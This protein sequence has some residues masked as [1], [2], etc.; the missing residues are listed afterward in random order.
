M[1]YL[2]EFF[3]SHLFFLKKKQYNNI[4]ELYKKKIHELD[5][6]QPKNSNLDIYIYIYGRVC[7][8]ERRFPAF[9]V[10]KFSLVYFFYRV[11]EGQRLNIIYIHIYIYC[12]LTNYRLHMISKLLENH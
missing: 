10:S 11:L 3:S 7:L 1:K 5:N 8:Y 12:I 2:Q 6:H 9:F 4:Q